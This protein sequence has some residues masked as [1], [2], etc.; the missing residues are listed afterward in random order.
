MTIDLGSRPA[1]FFTL[2][3]NKVSFVKPDQNK[4]SFEKLKSKFKQMF[5]TSSCTGAKHKTRTSFN[6]SPKNA[7]KKISQSRGVPVY[8]SNRIFVVS[9]SSNPPVSKLPKI[10]SPEPC[11]PVQKALV[12]AKDSTGLSS[13]QIEAPQPL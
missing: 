5:Q 4:T 9:P 12:S 2:P 13:T 1:H 8:N 3:A 11:S 7:N 10:P 6:G